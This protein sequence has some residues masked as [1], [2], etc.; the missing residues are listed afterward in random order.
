MGRCHPG[1]RRLLP[2]QPQRLCLVD[3]LVHPGFQDRGSAKLV[4]ALNDALHSGV[5]IADAWKAVDALGLDAQIVDAI[6]ADVDSEEAALAGC[7]F[8]SFPVGTQVL[9]ADGTLTPIQEL[10]L[11]DQVLATDPTTGISRAEP[12]T[13]TFDHT[14]G[15]LLDLTVAGG[16][17]TT[18]RSHL[19]YVVGKGW[20]FAS[21]L[22]RGDLLRLSDGSA[23]PVTALAPAAGGRTVFDL[24]VGGLHTF[25]VHLAGTPAQAVLVHNCNSLEKDAAAFPGLAHT[26][27]DHVTTDAAKAIAKAK[28]EKSGMTGVWASA[29]VAQQAV[30]QAI[31]QAVTK[32]PNVFTKWFADIGKGRAGDTLTLRGVLG[33]A[34]SSLGKIYH[35]DESVTDAGRSYVVVLKRARGYGQGFYIFTAYP[36]P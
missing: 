35:A 4:G 36:L 14:A 21:D 17:L 13:D 8:N 16:Q 18:T 9:R 19:L 25:Y 20:E 10:R 7:T 11:G 27:D 6:K 22:H 30:D 3:N 1:L 23:K 24:T 33:S 31:E 32:N 5:G 2:R 29:Q 12:V 28:K 26:L 34:G 15:P